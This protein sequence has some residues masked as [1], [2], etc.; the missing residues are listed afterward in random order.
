MDD[1]DDA[2]HCDDEAN[3]YQGAGSIRPSDQRE[4]VIQVED[5][6]RI[7]EGMEHVLVRDP[8]LPSTLGNDGLHASQVTLR[9]PRRQVNLRTG[10]AGSEQN[11]GTYALG[12]SVV[13]A[14]WPGL[15]SEARAE[16]MGSTLGRG[17]ALYQTAWWAPAISGMRVIWPSERR[18]MPSSEVRSWWVPEGS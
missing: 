3:L 5:V 6:D 11:D 7:A 12:Q 14:A 8:M 16:I 1:D 15:E 9:S 17:E 2:V 4:L 10:R 18:E 13:A